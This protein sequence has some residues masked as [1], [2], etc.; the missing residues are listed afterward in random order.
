MRDRRAARTEIYTTIAVK[1]PKARSLEE[2][3]D[4]AEEPGF[5]SSHTMPRFSL[6]PIMLGREH[7]TQR[8]DFSRLP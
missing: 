7:L 5:S 2:A 3:P 4:A 8:F 6:V 1:V